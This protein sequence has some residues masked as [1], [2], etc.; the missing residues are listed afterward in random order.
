MFLLVV[1]ADLQKTLK[2]HPGPNTVQFSVTSSY[3][4]EAMCSSRIFLWE[5]TDQIVISDIDG[6]ITKCV[7][8]ALHRAKLLIVQV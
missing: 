4:G 5:S 8:P 6:T 1:L 3:S 7:L 2:L